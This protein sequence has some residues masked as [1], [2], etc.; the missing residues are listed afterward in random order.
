MPLSPATEVSKTLDPKKPYYEQFGG[1]R[2]LKTVQRFLK[3]DTREVGS[4]SF[5]HG[6][7]DHGIETFY[8][9]NNSGS[10]IILTEHNESNGYSTHTSKLSL[11]IYGPKNV[12]EAVAKKFNDMFTPEGLLKEEILKL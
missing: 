12:G 7:G 3:P 11:E 10:L 1:W 5:S 2:A 4:R 8:I 9:D 6:M